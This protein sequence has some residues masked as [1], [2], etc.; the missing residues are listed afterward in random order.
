MREITTTNLEDFGYGERADLIRLL[1][2][3]NDQG[4]PEDF[5]A[6]G[7][8]A[9]MNKDS[10]NVF[11]TNDEFQVAMMNG[12]KLEIFYVCGMCGHEGFA[13]ECRLDDHGC[14]EC[15]EYEDH[16]IIEVNK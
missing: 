10:G 12:D 14:N 16:E 5:E 2:A 13:E 7:V 8:H 4:L 15:M 1:T 11:L 6:D 3:W 9:M